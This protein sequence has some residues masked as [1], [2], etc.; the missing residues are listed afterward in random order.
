[1]PTYPKKSISFSTGIKRTSDKNSPI[2]IHKPSSG[3]FLWA[4]LMKDTSK[5]FIT[6]RSTTIVRSASIPCDDINNNNNG[7]QR[8]DNDGETCTWLR[9]S[10]IKARIVMTASPKMLVFKSG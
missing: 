1:M 5:K 10:L 8:D 2:L 6:V 3:Y 4:Y 7:E 9:I